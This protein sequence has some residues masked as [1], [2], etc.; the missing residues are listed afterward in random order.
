MNREE[1]KEYIL[2]NCKQYFREDRSHKG[3][4]CPICN[5]G[6][7]RNGTGITTQDGTHFTCWAGC[8]TNAD[9]FDI[10]G[11]EY[12]TKDFNEQY[13]LAC[14]AFRI[15]PNNFAG[16]SKKTAKNTIENREKT[17]EKMKETDFTDFYKEAHKNINKTDYTQRRGLTDKTIS[18][19]MLGYVEN[20]KHPSN[21]NTKE[22]PRFIVPITKYSYLARDTRENLTAEEA[23]Y[24]KQKAKGREHANWIFN[25]RALQN[26]DEPIFILEGEIDAMSVIEVGGEAVAIGSV[27]YKKML[28]ELVKENKPQQ[29]L[30]IAL[31]SD[32]AGQ[33]ASAELAEEF[34]ALEIPYATVNINCGY[35]DA[36]EALV[37]NREALKK[38]V[39]EAKAEAINIKTEAEEIEAQRINAE[40]ALT[41]LETFK[42]K[43]ESGEKPIIVSTGFNKLDEVISGGLRAGL[44]IM[45]AIS[46]LGKTSFNIQLADNIAKQGR[47]VLFVSLEMGRDELI[48]KCLSRITYE[49]SISKYGKFN[50]AKTTIG[51]LNTHD[52]K[53][54]SQDTREIINEAIDEL[55]SRAQNLIILEGV[56]SIGVKEIRAEVEAIKKVRGI[57][58]VVF[59][60]Y[61]QILNSGDDRG[62]DKQ[63]T[64]RAVLELK[65]LSRD[66][67]IP[68]VCISSFNRDNYKEP[69]NLTSFKESGAIEYGSDVLLA[70][71]Y[72]EM[73]YQKGEKEGS[74]KRRDRVNSIIDT[75]LENGSR[76]QAQALELKVLKQRNGKRGTISIDFVPMFN[77]FTQAIRT[78]ADE[79]EEV[80]SNWKPAESHYK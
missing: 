9:I 73:D 39:A 2:N 68:V 54:Y 1:T 24:K 28:I 71:Q 45:G 23:Q 47:P 46:S 79:Y 8:F 21:P 5:S 65:R 80:G 38:A 75:A 51:I 35:K 4:I 69:V 56:G 44:Y 32:E 60:D 64:D 57:A 63:I 18:R 16:N 3:Y 50:T 25:K 66:E 77:Y 17:V 15:E 36:N 6:S 13:K 42:S 74:E 26:L 31:D 52:Y 58:P 37:Q 53:N 78:E 30:L 22:T 11:L 61:L 20:W 72:A 14:E 10:I 76:G 41:S 49:K 48:A 40:S 29:P 27:A 67:D 12:N 43:Y 19:F 7:G 34:K 70:L 33:K 59:I 55:S 62:T